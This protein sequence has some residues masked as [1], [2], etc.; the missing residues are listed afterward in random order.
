MTTATHA[1]LGAPHLLAP[2]RR[3]ELAQTVPAI[4]VEPTVV[5]ARSEP[6]LPAEAVNLGAAPAKL[7]L[8]EGGAAFL[9]AEV[10]RLEELAI[11][12]DRV[13]DAFEHGLAVLLD[14]DVARTGA[15]PPD[16]DPCWAE[17]LDSLPWHWDAADDGSARVHAELR[18]AGRLQPARV[19]LERLPR[20]GVRASSTLGLR[21]DGAGECRALD[22]YAL[23]SN[24][25][26]RLARTSV[27]RHGATAHWVCEAIV[28]AGPP[29]ARAAAAAIE[30]VAFARAA[31]G[32]SA[33]ALTD[34]RIANAY[35]AMRGATPDATRTHTKR[36]EPTWS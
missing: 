20:G 18:E 28:P 23:E 36:K 8:G 11:C 19:R 14:A 13:L 32:R 6:L 17:C 12:V 22:N 1:P 4:A 15:P 7:A 21:N 2:A 27:V 3:T 33:T 5:L 10:P 24:A 35:L 34:V 25:R 26:L 30:A 16:A 29:L 9:L 31:T